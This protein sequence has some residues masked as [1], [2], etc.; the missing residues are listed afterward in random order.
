MSFMGSNHYEILSHELA[1]Q[2][3]G[4]LVTCGSWQ[5][6]W[7][8]EGF[9]SYLSGLCYEFLAPEYWMSFKQG[10]RDFI[11]SQ[12]GGSVLVTDTNDIARLFDSRLTYAKGAFLLHMLR[13]VCGD[14]AFFGGV[15]SYLDD[16]SLRNGSAVTDD[17]IGHLESA[18]GVDLTEF[19][20]DWYVGEGYPTYQLIWA[21]DLN[22]AVTVELHQSS[23]HPSVD[24][25]EMPVPIRFSNGSDEQTIVLT[26]TTDGQ[27]FNFVL[28]FQASTA[29]LDPEI[30]ILSGQNLVLKVPV[31]AMGNDGLLLYPNPVDDAAWL[32]TGASLQGDLLL[33]MI[34]ATGRVVRSSRQAV[35]DQRVAL[36]ID[37]LGAGSYML[38]VLNGDRRAELRFVKR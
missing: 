4:D 9:A 28:P 15:N 18:S 17:L 37:G 34:D 12:P 3:F 10:R 32:Y 33:E 7:L 1:H 2:W 26:H 35:K 16:P 27:V 5:D 14:E 8:N 38:R 29:E 11:T 30:R 31:A 20:Q 13:W 21:Q 19:M 36:P 25:F 23:S 22:G 24:F 6:L